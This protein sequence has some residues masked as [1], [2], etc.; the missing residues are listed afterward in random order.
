MEARNFF[1]FSTGVLIVV[2]FMASACKK[3]EA[4]SK[5]CGTCP[6]GGGLA[7]PPDGFTYTKNMGDAVTADSSFILGNNVIVAYYH[8]GAYRLTIKLKSLLPGV[9]Q[10]TDPPSGN[11]VTY[12]ETAGATY[13]AQSGNVTITDYRLKGNTRVTSGS[14]I[15]EGAGGG[16][17][18]I[19]G[20]FQNV[21]EHKP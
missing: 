21:S 17:V 11:T 14:F 19:N 16:Y 15:T 13:N 7:E 20:Q 2:L 3:K 10:I 5:S 9:Y 12:S 4:S 8:G 1:K 18:K 6:P